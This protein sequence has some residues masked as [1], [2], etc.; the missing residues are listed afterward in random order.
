MLQPEVLA[1]LCCPEDHSALTPASKSLVAEINNAIRR[2]QLRNRAGRLIEQTLDGG[3]TR[4]SGDV[5]YP[6]IDGI[7]VL[8]REEAIP[9]KSLPRAQD[10]S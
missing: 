9:I 8:V 1:I 3:L 7:P 5:I 4:A 2:G 6:I 10:G